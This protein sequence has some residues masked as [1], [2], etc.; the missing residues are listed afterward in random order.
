LNGNWLLG[1]LANLAGL[2]YLDIWNTNSTGNV[3]S[4]NWISMVAT[5]E[6]SIGV[7]N[8]ILAGDGT[9]YAAVGTT[10]G[11]AGGT[12][13]RL[14]INIENDRNE[15]SDFNFSHV[16]IWDVSLTVAEMNIVASSQSSYINTG[17][18]V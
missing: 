16:F 12:N 6:L 8:N 13:K 10:N 9:S 14:T 7:P 18:L 11:G 4:Q 5:N 15:K 17:L 1:H 3:N 2:A